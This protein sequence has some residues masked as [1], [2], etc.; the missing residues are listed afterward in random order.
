[1]LAKCFWSLCASDECTTCVFFCACANRWDYLILTG[2]AAI[3]VMAQVQNIALLPDH[4]IFKIL[5]CF[6]IP[7]LKLSHCSTSNEDLSETQHAAFKLCYLPPTDE[8]LLLYLCNICNSSCVLTADITVSTAASTCPGPIFLVYWHQIL[9]SRSWSRDSILPT[10]FLSPT[11]SIY[12]LLIS[13][14]HTTEGFATVRTVLLWRPSY[15]SK[16]KVTPGLVSQR[17]VYSKHNKN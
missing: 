3:W 11:L 1:M 14:P 4:N 17:V 12:L 8:L 13:C 5:P 15:V 16:A 7:V 9:S 2:A 6:S 10:Q